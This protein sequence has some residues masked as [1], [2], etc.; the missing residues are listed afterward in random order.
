MQ[1][2][3]RILLFSALVFA[4]L[5]IALYLHYPDYFAETNLA[6]ALLSGSR[7]DLKL[8]V[9]ALSPCLL[10]LLIP[11]PQK[12]A[13][14][15]RHILS[16]ISGFIFILLIILSLANL[17]YFGEIHRHISH[18]L[19]PM[20]SDIP[21]MLHLILK[22][23]LLEL[24][25]TIIVLIIFIYLWRKYII[26]Y[27]KRP[28]KT[29]IGKQIL[30]N[31][32]TLILCVFLAR[33]MVLKGKPLNSI[34]AFT[35]HG[36]AQANLTLNGA[37]LA[38]EYLEKQSNIEPLYYL[39]EH[40]LATYK[41]QKDPNLFLKQNT[42][43]YPQKNI[44]FILL[45]G[46]SYQYIDALAQGNYHTTPFIDALITKSKVWDNFYAAGQRSIIGIQAALTGTPALPYRP[47]IGFGLELNNISRIAKLAQQNHYQTLM[48]QTSNRRSYHLDGIARALGFQNYYGKEDIPII[49]DYPQATPPFGWDYDSLLFMAEKLKQTREPFFAFL[50]TG[51]THEPFANAGEEF[52]IY[53]HQEKGE[54]GLLNTMRYSD[55]AL[56]Q[57]F[58][59]AKT[60]AWY[61][62]TIFIISADHTYNAGN[63]ANT[64]ARYHIPFMIFD[65]QNPEGERIHRLSS[66]Y[67]ILPT[68]SAL[69]NIK[70]PI[71]SFGENL[72][73]NPKERPIPIFQDNQTI[74]IFPDG[75]T[76]KIKN[77][78]NTE[79]KDPAL[80]DILWRSQYADELLRQNQWLP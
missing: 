36:Q 21:S 10:L 12:I 43:D 33:G 38:L 40:H 14:I 30:I 63:Y 22:S 29:H 24:F 41:T 60:Q 17:S 47:T 53:P 42:H 73:D 50:F 61:E 37:L 7:F 31:S 18:E 77:T 74:I 65:P 44:I 79:Y 34:D 11:L 58:Q 35:G 25:F 67:D 68:L 26:N 1:L 2:P 72:L 48:M 32:L 16:S 66:Q 56:E 76:Q 4:L 19:E 9:F 23:R 15:I 5:R 64:K 6:L 39:S 8:T 52:L 28:I 46:W 59:Y 70:T 55:W 80:I 78:I 3:Y 20:L 45:E 62:N 57:F 51:T 13:P 54:N 49:R 69:M 27:A 75:S 71:A